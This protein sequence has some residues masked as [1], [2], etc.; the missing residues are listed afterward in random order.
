MDCYTYRV[1]QGSQ[2]GVQACTEWYDRKGNQA[3]YKQGEE[4]TVGEGQR[5]E[6]QTIMEI[7]KGERGGCFEEDQEDQVFDGHCCTA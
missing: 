7:Q 4:S 5:D 3:W 1:T 2:E 6:A